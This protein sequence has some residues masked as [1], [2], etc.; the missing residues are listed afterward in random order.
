[1]KSQQAGILCTRQ[2]GDASLVWE[3]LPADS[4]P[5]A[6]RSQHGCST[7]QEALLA[8]QLICFSLFSADVSRSFSTGYLTWPRPSWFDLGVDRRV[9]GRP[10]ARPGLACPLAWGTTGATPSAAGCFCLGCVEP[11]FPGGR[12][13]SF[14]TGQ[15]IFTLER[16]PSKEAM[17]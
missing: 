14:A 11:N 17:A 9:R 7:K 13:W 5:G 16:G 1:M 3:M 8:S 15:P 2:A 4:A 6:K 12:S 10:R